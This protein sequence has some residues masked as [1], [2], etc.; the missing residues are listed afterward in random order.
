ML[1]TSRNPDWH[2]LATPVQVEVFT[3]QESI[4]LL[5]GRVPQLSEPA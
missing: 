3:R 4:S 1:I 5:R 2:E